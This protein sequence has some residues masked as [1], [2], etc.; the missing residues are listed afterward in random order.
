VA[1]SDDETSK[2]KRFL[3]DVDAADCPT[4]R[5]QQNL[6]QNPAHNVLASYALSNHFSVRNDFWSAGNILKKTSVV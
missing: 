6:H 1:T 3:G 5:P 2:K 4:C